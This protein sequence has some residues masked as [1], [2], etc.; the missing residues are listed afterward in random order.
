MPIGS[1]PKW[2]LIVILHQ[3]KKRL[4]LN[5]IKNC[6]QISDQSSIQL[7]VRRHNR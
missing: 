1:I 7:V 2:E 4:T 6:I 3:K 5:F